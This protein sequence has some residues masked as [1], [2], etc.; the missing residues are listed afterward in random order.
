MTCNKCFEKLSD[1]FGFVEWLALYIFISNTFMYVVWRQ[2]WYMALGN[3]MVFPVTQ[4]IFFACMLV[5]NV[6]NAWAAFELWRCKNW[7]EDWVPLF[8]NLLAMIAINVFPF[9]VMTT[10]EALAYIF[11]S[12]TIIGLSVAY[13]IV[14][15]KHDARAGGVGIADCFVGLAFFGYA[16][17]AW[18][19]RR[20]AQARFARGEKDSTV[21]TASVLIDTTT[22]RPVTETS[23]EDE[24][25]HSDTEYS[26]D[27]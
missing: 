19:S 13:T 3:Y 17:S 23:P 4:S 6:A 26:D 25:E 16:F 5:L 12:L 27:N 1:G 10:K 8:L 22:G 7:D 2:R 20:P 11:L 15:W 21:V 9:M 14:S 24:V 18:M